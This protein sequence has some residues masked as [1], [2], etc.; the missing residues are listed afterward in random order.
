MTNVLS[1]LF[2]DLARALLATTEARIS[3]VS[4]LYLGCISRLGRVGERRVERL[5]RRAAQVMLAR[6]GPLRAHT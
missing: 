1:P 3:A 5:V 4:R 2:V 6:V